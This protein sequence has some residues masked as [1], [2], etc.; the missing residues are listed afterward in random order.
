MRMESVFHDWFEK[1]RAYTDYPFCLFEKKCFVVPGV[2]RSNT[3][4]V[5]RNA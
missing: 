5:I 2:P 1:E 3:Q 4:Y